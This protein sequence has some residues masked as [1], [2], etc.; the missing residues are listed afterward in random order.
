M[1]LRVIFLFHRTRLKVKHFYFSQNRLD[2]RDM[3]TLFK[4]VKKS[5]VYLKKVKENFDDYFLIKTNQKMKT[6]GGKGFNALNFLVRF[7]T[8][9]NFI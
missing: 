7:S 4:K 8:F 6:N 5:N 9:G 2:K 3:N 1:S